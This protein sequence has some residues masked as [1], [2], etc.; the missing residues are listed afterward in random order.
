MILINFIL[1]VVLESVTDLINNIQNYYETAIAN[2]NNL[3]EDNILKSR[4]VKDAIQNIQNLDI[5]Q[6]F[7]LDLNFE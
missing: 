4:V 3:P 5:K 2:Y 1:P 6:Y 7:Q